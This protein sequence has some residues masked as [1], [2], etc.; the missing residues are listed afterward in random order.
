MANSNSEIQ[1]ILKIFEKRLSDVERKVIE[2]EQITEGKND[3]NN[4][5][6]ELLSE[7]E[8]TIVF[9]KSELYH[10][11]STLDSFY[12]DHFSKMKAKFEVTSI[13]DFDNTDKSEPQR[14]RSNSIKCN[15]V[16]NE[17]AVGSSTRG[18]IAKVATTKLNTLMRAYQHN[19]TERAKESPP[20]EKTQL[21]PDRPLN[22]SSPDEENSVVTRKTEM[23]FG[24]VVEFPP[25]EDPEAEGV[26][27]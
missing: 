1:E 12:P 15:K 25:G 11:R 4:S 22:S 5:N 6:E 17:S 26:Q 8:V 9:E 20:K 10:I 2:L 3:Q 16:G 21:S 19:A 18:T 13:V 7:K 23:R 27:Y 24:L 14:E